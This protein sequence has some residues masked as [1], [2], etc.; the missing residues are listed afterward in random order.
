MEPLSITASVIS[1]T[2]LAYKSCKALRNTIKGIRNAPATLKDL[3]MALEAFEHVTQSLHHDLDG[4]D[5]AVFSPDQK[6]SLRALEPVLK[7]C[8]TVCDAFSTR[9]AALM[10]HSD[11]GH[12]SWI[13]RFQ[14]HFNDSD[15]HILKE[16][17]TQCQRTLNDAL[18][19]SN[20]YELLQIQWGVFYGLIRRFII[21]EPQPKHVWLLTISPPVAHNLSTT[22]EAE[23]KA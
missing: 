10:S 21:D 16:N 20:L 23:S 2:G 5:D 14:F 6:E 9:L 13:D 1:V 8:N 19:F 22:L 3:Y 18:S 15:I 12:M 7:Y 4:L 11:H 17:L